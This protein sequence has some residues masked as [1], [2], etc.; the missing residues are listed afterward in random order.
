[1]ELSG[2]AGDGRVGQMNGQV[3]L[4]FGAPFQAGG[5]RSAAAGV[6]Q[7]FRSSK[8]TIQV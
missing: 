1:M 8:L 5:A 6:R 4:I 3:K 2:R 7:S